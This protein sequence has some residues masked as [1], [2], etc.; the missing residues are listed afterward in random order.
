MKNLIKLFTVTLLLMGSL[1]YAQQTPA[2]K[3][4]ESILIT[5]V[6]AH[7][8]NGQVIENAAIGFDNGKI[9]YVGSVSEAT[10]GDFSQQIE[11]TGKH[12]YPG[13][14]ATNASLGLS[15]IDAVRATRDFD[16]V[17]GFLPHIR[18]LIAY[19]LSLIHI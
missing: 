4:T 17:G 16:E 15:E 14:I 19:N 8:G 1:T 2:P 3:Q 9:T 12:V 7:I 18:S 6:T 5:G 11:A 10:V 13:F